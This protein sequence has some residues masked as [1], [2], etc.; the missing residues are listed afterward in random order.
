MNNSGLLKSRFFVITTLFIVSF[1]LLFGGYAHSQFFPYCPYISPPSLCYLLSYPYYTNYGY[2]NSIDGYLLGYIPFTPF[3]NQNVSAA[4]NIAGIP[5]YSYLGSPYQTT[6]PYQTVPGSINPYTR[7]T[8]PAYI[9]G[10]PDFYLN[11]ILLQ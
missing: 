4:Y 11:W 5:T 2:F 9:Y 7:F 6:F 3:L 8:Y 1:I 10:I